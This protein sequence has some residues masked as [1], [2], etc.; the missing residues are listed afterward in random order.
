VNRG[1]LPFRRVAKLR[2]PWNRNLVVKVGRD[3][4]EIEPSVGAIL[5]AEFGTNAGPFACAS[6]SG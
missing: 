6:V 2:N 5:L 1:A 3:G 4:T